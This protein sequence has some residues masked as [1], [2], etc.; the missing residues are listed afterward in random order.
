MKTTFGCNNG[1]RSKVLTS[2]NS[3]RYSQCICSA[4]RSRV[5]LRITLQ[6]WWYPDPYNH[7]LACDT[8]SHSWVYSSSYLECPACS[9]R[10]LRG[11]ATVA[12]ICL[13]VARRQVTGC[14]AP[15]TMYRIGSK[16]R[17]ENPSENPPPLRARDGWYGEGIWMSVS[18]VNEHRPT[19]INIRQGR[20]KVEGCSPVWAA[21]SQD[22]GLL[23]TCTEP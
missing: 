10:S 23:T 17:Q 15:R 11:R 19:R 8:R 5:F 12:L 9:C 7:L 4:T 14:E 13:C 20:M 3:M 16:W 6:R 1:K 18:V 22:A 2:P 21:C